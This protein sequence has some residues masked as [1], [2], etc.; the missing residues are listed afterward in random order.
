MW[1]F[2]HAIHDR[3]REY[4]TWGSDMD[5]FCRQESGKSA[6]VKA[7]A[8]Q[9]LAQLDKLNADIARHKFEGPGS[10]AYWKDR[11]PV[12][13]QMVKADN[14]AEV[15]GIEKIRQLGDQQDER[16]SRCRQ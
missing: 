16:V 12:L 5:A 10:E 6:A 8:D 3:I 13:I 7:V 4:R 14:Y 2:V 1:Y 11:I 9:T 15:G